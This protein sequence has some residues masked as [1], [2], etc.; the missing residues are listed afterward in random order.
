MSLGTVTGSRFKKMVMQATGTKGYLSSSVQKTVRQ[1][2]GDKYLKS[3]AKVSRQQATKVMKALKEGGLAHKTGTTATKF[4]KQGFAKEERRQDTIK[5]QNIQ[6]R[7][8]EIANEKAAAEKGKTT[9]SHQA[10]NTASGMA[11]MH[12][13]STPTTASQHGDTFTGTSYGST[14]LKPITQLPKPIEKPKQ[15]VEEEQNLID[16]AID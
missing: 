13:A 16:L 3:N 1:M 5:R 4:V 7:A 2:G 8:Q 9:G 11:G 15:W 12:Y 10:N 6:G 14:N